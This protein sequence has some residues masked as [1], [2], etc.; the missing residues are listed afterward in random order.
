MREIEK[1]LHFMRFKGLTPSEFELDTIDN[2]SNMLKI[3]I[4][5]KAKQVLKLNM[6]STKA[7]QVINTQKKEKALKIVQTSSNRADERKELYINNEYRI[8]AGCLWKLHNE[9]TRHL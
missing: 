8:P 4:N 7:V 1:Q 3:F 2:K 9:S 6:A 5:L